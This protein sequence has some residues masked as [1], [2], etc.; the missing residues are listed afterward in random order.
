VGSIAGEFSIRFEPNSTNTKQCAPIKSFG[1]K[2]LEDVVPEVNTRETV[3][4]WCSVDT[5]IGTLTCVLEENHCFDAEM[6]ADEL[7]LEEHIDFREDHRSRLLGPL[8]A[9]LC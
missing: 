1:K 6:Y 5:R 3:A 2:Y 4:H 7:Q 8:L 9:P